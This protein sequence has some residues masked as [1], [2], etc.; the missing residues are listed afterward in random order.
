MIQELTRNPEGG[1]P[2]PIAIKP[3]GDKFVR[4]EAQAARFEAGQVHLPREAPWLSTLLHE[5][6]AFPNARH[7]DQVDSI[8]QFL[9]WAEAEHLRRGTV[10]IYGPKIFYG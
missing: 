2:R 4:M 1:V 3:D 10:A 5:L 9:N 7:D 8:S 6:L